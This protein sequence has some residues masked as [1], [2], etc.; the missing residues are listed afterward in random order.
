MS[1]QAAHCTYSQQHDHHRPVEPR[2]SSEPD[3]TAH[4]QLGGLIRHTALQPHNLRTRVPSLIAA[5]LGRGGLCGQG[6]PAYQ[7]LIDLAFI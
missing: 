2:K 3:R 4:L 5:C 7:N 6:T 1:V